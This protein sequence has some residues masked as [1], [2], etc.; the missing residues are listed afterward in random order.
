[1]GI[2]ELLDKI[3]GLLPAESGADLK[4]AVT[5]ALAEASLM[6]DKLTA[7]NKENQKRREENEA[8]EAKVADLEAKNAKLEGANNSDE[9]T[10]YKSKAEAYDKLIAEQNAALITKWKGIDDKLGK[11]TDTDKRFE[12]ITAFKAKLSIPAEGQEL[13]AEIAREN[14]KLYEV[15]ESTGI[16]NDQEKAP[17]YGKSK[18]GEPAPKTGADAVLNIIKRG[19]K[20]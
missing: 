1:M 13:T 4:S 15:L 20:Q 19:N 10:A 3:Q 14:I 12:T 9:L 5:D 18:G 17:E 16:M 7:K 11:I 8:L 6:A 2:K